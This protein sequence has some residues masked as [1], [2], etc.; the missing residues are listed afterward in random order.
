MTREKPRYRNAADSVIAVGSVLFGPGAKFESLEWPTNS[1]LE[2]VNDSAWRVMTYYT[3]RRHQPFFP[4]H[5]TVGG[6]V[7]LPAVMHPVEDY[8]F[9]LPGLPEKDFDIPDT[10]PVYRLGAAF[11]VGRKGFVIGE[12]A[13][14][15]GWPR[16]GLEPVNESA[17]L[18]RAY[19]MLHEKHP[20]LPPCPWN[21]YDDAPWLPT[22]RDLEERKAELP[23]MAGLPS[24]QPSAW[25]GNAINRPPPSPMHG[26]LKPPW[27]REAT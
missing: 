12:L 15:L 9:N 11:R 21:L 10:A 17:T 14:Y 26:K 24:F 27:R 16:F 22:L 7:Y 13:T 4:Q 5:L 3:R 20:D 18:V 25:P 6:R 2:P 1:E 19:F 23:P 8:D